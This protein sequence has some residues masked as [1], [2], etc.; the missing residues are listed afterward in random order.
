[1]A[2]VASIDLELDSSQYLSK[3]DTASLSIIGDLTLEMWVK[4]ESI[5]GTN[6]LISKYIYNASDDRSYA[7]DNSADTIRL[8]I[9]D[10]GIGITTVSVSW[11]PSLAT[12]YHMAVTYDASAGSATFYI[13]GVQQGATQT[14]LDTSIYDGTAPFEIGAVDNGGTINFDGLID[15]VRVWSDIRTATE[16]SDNYQKEL[17]GSEANLVGYWKLNNDLLDETSNN[18][19][20]TNNNS[21]TFSTDVP[22]SG[23]ASGN[24]N[25]FQFF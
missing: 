1:M 24:S 23:A 15:E 10:D 2:N 7:F 4:F 18:N 20:L 9:S 5:T 11:T 13:D 3:T 12:W 22:F 25:F 6:R 19:D 17:T 16:I 14:G 21:A 8:V